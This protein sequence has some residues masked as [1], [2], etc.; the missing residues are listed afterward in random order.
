MLRIYIT[1][2]MDIKSQKNL[3]KIFFILEFAKKR[4]IWINK[5]YNLYLNWIVSCL[6]EEV[7]NKRKK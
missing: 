1:Y 2:D 5:E 7:T 4:R 6:D 3:L